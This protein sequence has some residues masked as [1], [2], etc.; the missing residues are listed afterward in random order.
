MIK[1]A[2][3]KDA[4]N[5]TRTAYGADAYQ[6][7]LAKLS[8]ADRALV[9]GIILPGTWYPIAS[10]DRFL[11]A[12]RAEAAARRGDSELA[13]DLR[14]MRESGGPV[15][16]SIYKIIL[17][18]VG[19]TTAID[20]AIGLFNRAFSEGRCEIVENVRGRALVRY[21]DGSPELLENLSHH[22]PTA[23]IWV[24]EE[25]GARDPV[26]TIT[27]RDVISGKLFFEVTVT[28]RG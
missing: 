6:A 3:I 16:K 24:L 10:W 21:L 14:N 20:R 25:N 28:Y 22:L 13:F 8:D 18:L 9:N 19:P 15:V 23:L 17:N 11:K 4:R 5:W 7:A 12:M 2:F 26:P 1:G 27:R